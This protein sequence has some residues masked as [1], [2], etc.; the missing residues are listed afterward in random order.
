[1]AKVDAFYRREAQLLQSGDFKTWLTL[2]SEDVRYKIYHSVFVSRDDSDDQDSPRSYY[3]DEDI[4]SLRLRIKKFGSTMAW[5]E[6]PKSRRRYFWQTLAIDSL[7]DGALCVQSNI[8]VFQTRGDQQGNRFVGERKDHLLETD[9]GL[10][11]LQ[12]DVDLDKT[13]VTDRFLNTLF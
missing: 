13:L 6:S 5:T 11:L 4:A 2:L 1:M 10:K 3:Y 8:L 12:R 9:E 7:D